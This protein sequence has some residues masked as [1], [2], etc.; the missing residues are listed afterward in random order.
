MLTD[1]DNMCGSRL[2]FRVTNYLDSKMT[3]LIENSLIFLLFQLIK[4][5]GKPNIDFKIKAENVDVAS[6]YEN[7]GNFFY[8]YRIVR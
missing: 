3:S 2:E 6:G 5:H 1:Y 8:I 4:N 7:T